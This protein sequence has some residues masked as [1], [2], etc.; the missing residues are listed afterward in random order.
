MPAI[1]LTYRYPVNNG[2]RIKQMTEQTGA[3][4]K[5]VTY[6]YDRL[7][8]LAAAQSRGGRVGLDYQLDG[9]GNRKGQTVTAGRPGHAVGLRCGEEPDPGI[10]YD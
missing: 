8:R 10:G 9:F 5:T 6:Q 3:G 1:N 2:S 7:R 4:V